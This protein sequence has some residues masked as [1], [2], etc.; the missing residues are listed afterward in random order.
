MFHGL[1]LNNGRSNVGQERVKNASRALPGRAESLH[2]LGSLRGVFGPHAFDPFAPHLKALPLERTTHERTNVVFLQPKLPFD[3]LK[4]RPVFPSHLDDPVQILSRP[5]LPRQCGAVQLC[6]WRLGLLFGHGIE[7]PQ[8]GALFNNLCHLVL[9]KRFHFA[10]AAAA[11]LVGCTSSPEHTDLGPHADLGDYHETGNCA[12]A[13]TP[14][15]AALRQAKR[16]EEGVTMVK[17]SNGFEVFTQQFGESEKVK[18][19]VLHGGPACTH[20]YMLNVAYQL[21]GHKGLDATDAEVHMYDQLG[22]FY[23]DQPETDLWNIERW[24]QEVEEVRQ[25]LGM[26][27]TNFYLL[28]NSWGGILAMEYALV[29]QEKLKGLIVCNMQSSIPDYAAYNMSTLRPQMRP[30]LVDSLEAYEAAGD[31][32]NPTYLELIDKEFYRKH[33]CRLEQWPEEV[34]GSFAR[35]N[36]KLYDLMQGPSE[37]KVGGRIID[38]DITPRLS[39]IAAPTLMVGATHDTMDPAA[40][41][42]QATLVQRGRA[43]ICENGSHLALWDD[44]DAFFGGVTDFI[45]D[46]EEG[47][48]P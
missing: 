33:V 14:E 4:R 15:D 43:L 48:F 18:V 1:E 39:E 2:G 11:L 40:M 19:L 41:A 26:D 21:P 23:S 5:I 8:P 38:W 32:Q 42:H 36:Y 17:L 10:F 46:V 16:E 3:G 28:G 7:T 47:R 31:F 44:A 13:F 22:S 34:V 45:R 30:S 27:S 35:L 6:G 24:V 9:M 12:M 37:F 25:A 20:E 29:H